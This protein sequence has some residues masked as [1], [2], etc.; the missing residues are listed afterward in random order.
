MNHHKFRIEFKINPWKYQEII[1]KQFE[2]EK[3]FEKNFEKKS[4]K[5]YDIITTVTDSNTDSNTDTNTNKSDNNK[6]LEKRGKILIHNTNINSNTNNNK[7]KDENNYRTY[8]D[9]NDRDLMSTLSPYYTDKRDWMVCE[10]HSC[11]MI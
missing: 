1:E 11:E 3:T 5:N 2:N 4:Q 10:S 9:S 8:I 7:N 6:A